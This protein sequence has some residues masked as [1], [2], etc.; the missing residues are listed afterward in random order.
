MGEGRCRMSHTSQKGVSLAT[1]TPKRY[2][3]T[4]QDNSTWEGTKREL[5]DTDP[6]WL[7]Y[8]VEIQLPAP[9]DTQEGYSGDVLTEIEQDYADAD[10][11]HRM[12]RSA[13][14]YQTRTAQRVPAGV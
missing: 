1:T 4:F 3:V 12:P 7:P 5:L 14:H 9:R 8:A 11:V 6:S 10:K 13:I 2:R